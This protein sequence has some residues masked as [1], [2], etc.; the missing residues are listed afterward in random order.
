[1]ESICFG[2]SFSKQIRWSGC[3]VFDTYFVLVLLVDDGRLRWLFDMFV[4]EKHMD[5]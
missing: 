5:M 1:M 4:L 3:S 2:K